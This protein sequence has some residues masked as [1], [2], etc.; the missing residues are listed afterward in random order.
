MR[1]CLSP[2][3]FWRHQSLPV[4]EARASL[5][6]LAQAARPSALSGGI[7]RGRFKMWSG[8]RSAAWPWAG[9]GYSRLHTEP[10]A[11]TR[12]AAAVGVVRWLPAGL[13][14]L[15]ARHGAPL[16]CLLLLVLSGDLLTVGQRQGQRQRLPPPRLHG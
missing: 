7:L 16:F 12:S 14:D 3:L 6:P 5:M 2:S 9:G 13:R 15:P 11:A 8:S 4:P 10:D 1:R